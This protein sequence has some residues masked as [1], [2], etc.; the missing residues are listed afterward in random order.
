MELSWE[1]RQTIRSLL[2]PW[3]RPSSSTSVDPESVSNPCLIVPFPGFD[4]FH[5]GHRQRL[6]G[7][8]P[9]PKSLHQPDTVRDVGRLVPPT[10]GNRPFVL[11]HHLQTLK[12]NCQRQT[13]AT[14]SQTSP[15]LFPPRQL[16]RRQP[17]SSLT[18]STS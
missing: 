4:R 6:Q 11:T 12:H 14:S 13:T 2:Q 10:T 9:H 5:R 8:S 18:N 7:R 15:P 16:L 3:L 1:S 17:R